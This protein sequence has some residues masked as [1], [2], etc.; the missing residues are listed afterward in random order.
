MESLLWR[1]GKKLLQVDEKVAV[2]V[3]FFFVSDTIYTAQSL[4][5]KYLIDNRIAGQLPEPGTYGCG[6]LYIIV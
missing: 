2:R 1:S 4:L 6:M 3:A 5:Y